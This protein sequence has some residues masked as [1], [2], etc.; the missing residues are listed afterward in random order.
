M[1]TPSGIIVVLKGPQ[2][3]EH[4][5]APNIEETRAEV[6]KFLLKTEARE[7]PEVPAGQ[8]CFK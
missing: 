7:N 3:S 1:N 2:E 8:V 4:P 6:A 5:H